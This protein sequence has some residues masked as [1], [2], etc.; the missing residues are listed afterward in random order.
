MGVKTIID[1]E[2]GHN[3]AKLIDGLGFEY[4]QVPVKLWC[5]QDKDLIQ[6]LKIITNTK[7]YPVFIYCENGLE[8]ASLMVAIYRV[9][10][11][12]WTTYDATK[13]FCK[14]EQKKYWK[15]VENYLDSIDKD[16]IKEAIKQ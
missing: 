7:Y 4:F 11:Q 10:A 15:A 16:K 1:L 2:P 6:F 5:V 3:D 8:K 13:E 12:N 9:Y 14:T